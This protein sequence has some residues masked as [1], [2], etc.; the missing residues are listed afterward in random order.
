MVKDK[1]VAY[2]NIKTE[3]TMKVSGLM[4]SDMV[5]VGFNSK[6]VICTRENGQMIK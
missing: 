4:M 2:C 5:S 3:T 6:L 1:V